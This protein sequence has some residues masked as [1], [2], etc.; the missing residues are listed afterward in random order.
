[1]EHRTYYVSQRQCLDIGPNLTVDRTWATVEVNLAIVSGKG[2]QL[3]Y[4][5]PVLTSF[6]SV[7]SNAPSHLLEGVPSSVPRGLCRF[8]QQ[9]VP[10]EPPKVIHE[11]VDDEDKVTQW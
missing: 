3:L 1:V 10:D 6:F 5:H 11:D 4:M 9:A 7:P 2:A 8:E